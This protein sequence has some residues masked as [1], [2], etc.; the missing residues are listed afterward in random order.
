MYT[1]PR[2][3]LGLSLVT[4]GVGV[5]AQESARSGKDESSARGVALEEITVTGSHIRGSAAV[6]SPL[7]VITRED[8]EKSGYGR[9]QDYMATLPQ[10]FDGSTSEGF[11]NAIDFGAANG[12]RGKGLDL[13]GLGASGTLVLIDGRRQPAGGLE[14]SF[15]DISSIPAA[16]IERIEIL[17]DGA[18]ALYGSDAVGGVV[19]YILRKDY[20]GVEVNARVASTDEFADE[21]Q[22]AALGGHS[23]RDANLLF[24]YQYSRRDALLNKD[25]PYS[26]LNQD[27]RSLGGSDFRDITA[28]PGTILNFV[29]P[30]YAI[31]RGQNGTGLTVGQLIP[32]EANYQA[33]EPG[34]SAQPGQ[35]Q[36]DAF[37]RF[38]WRPNERTEFYAQ[39]RY[40]RRDMD[41]S[42][43]GEVSILYVPETNPFSVNPYGGGDLY[44]AYDFTKIVG[45]VVESGQVDTYTLGVGADVTL[46]GSWVLKVAADYGKEK[47]QSSSSNYLD[48]GRLDACLSGMATPAQCP[49][50][51]LNVFGDGTIAVNDSATINF[52]R[53]TSFVEGTSAIKT[54]SAVA[55]GNLFQL[56]AGSVKLA[57]G[58]DY[59]DESLS[60][61]GYRFSPSN[62]IRVPSSPG[63]G[64]PDRQV[65]AAFAE[66]LIPILGN[67]AGGD[68]ARLE[69]SLAGRY[70]DYSDFGSTSDPKIGVS[71]APIQDLL[72]RASWGTSFRAPRFNETN[73]SPSSNRSLAFSLPDPRSSTGESLVL[74]LEGAA[75]GIGPETAD[76]W[77]TGFDLQPTALAGLRISATYFHIDYEDKIAV[78]GDF[79][80]TLLAESQWEAII[81]R[82][83]T[84]AQVDAICARSDFEDFGYGRCPFATPPAAILDLRLRN[85]SQVK[86]RGIDLDLN[87]RTDV[88]AGQLGFGL[89]GTYMLDYQRAASAGAE[90]ASLVDTVGYPAALRLRGTMGWSMQ[91]WAAN[92]M[93]NHVGAYDDPIRDR[94]V[95]S[96][97]TVDLSL[98]Y[99]FADAGWLDNTALQLAT[100]NAFDRKPPFV[101]VRAG[102]DSAN[103]RETGR[104]V[105]LSATKRW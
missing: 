93:V 88:L 64:D 46:S 13:R 82:D 6:G 24:G 78:G 10:N 12:S 90:L 44:V 97:T 69:L 105:S 72:L 99:Q 18:S 35:E 5:C 65:S 61:A 70:E 40:G 57:V 76:I 58:A 53:D 14:G 32:G 83:P 81:T 100:T 86:L 47:N 79:G 17:T 62:L 49:G 15:V 67:P 29:D 66:L 96:W 59:R 42:R 20:D 103:A 28:D 74:V 75:P 48:Y 80:S 30:S 1:L 94:D 104:S 34:L 25:R 22:L 27:Y 26:S 55:D 43:A 60:T 51:P 8:L 87:Y 77:T 33:M 92:V 91:G 56:P 102:F 41:F 50:T 21:M 23:W 9:I 11:G 37:L 45:P 89:A 19:N 16:A 63:V 98:G 71:F 101:N 85:L 73:Q 3:M 4:C 36:H 31:P 39:G 52:I 38:A 95:S 2:L 7:V 54:L 84:P 68:G